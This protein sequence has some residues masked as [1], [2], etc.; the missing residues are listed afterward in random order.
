LTDYERKTSI[1]VTPHLIKN[2]K[3]KLG[4]E[5]NI[6]SDYA[7]PGTARFHIGR[8]AICRENNRSFMIYCRVFLELDHLFQSCQIWSVT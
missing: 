1:V 5:F 2:L 4:K 3:E 7:M 8:P 6:S